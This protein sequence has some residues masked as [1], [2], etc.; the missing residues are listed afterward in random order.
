LEFLRARGSKALAGNA[1]DRDDDDDD[2][3]AARDRGGSVE[4]LRRAR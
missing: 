1:V 4:V 3:D 2:H